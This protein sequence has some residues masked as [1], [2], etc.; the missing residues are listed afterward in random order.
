MTREKL[1][2]SEYMGEADL[3]VSPVNGATHATESSINRLY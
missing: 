1:D 2:E 3:D